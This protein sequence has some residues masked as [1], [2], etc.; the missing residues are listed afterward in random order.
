MADIFNYSVA[1]NSGKG[2]ITAQESADFYVEA[3]PGNVWVCANIPA[4]VAWISKVSGT[5]KTLSE[6]QSLVDT[7]VAAGQAAWDAQTV[8]QKENPSNPRPTA[9]ALPSIPD[10]E[11]DATASNMTVT[12]VNAANGWALK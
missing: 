3:F 1:T 10:L 6:A 5:V 11:S 4:S 12:Y 9:I 2:F 7:A 8:E